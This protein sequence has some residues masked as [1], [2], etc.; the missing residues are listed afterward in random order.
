MIVVQ[1]TLKVKSDRINDFIRYT[2]ENVRNS[3]KETGVRRFEFYQEKESNNIFVLFEIYNSTDDQLK[4][5]ETAHFKNWKT[6]VMSVLEEP[7]IVK[8]YEAV[9]ADIK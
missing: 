4:H 8:Q 3:V 2:K 5:R 1:V 7:Y 9:S 6:N